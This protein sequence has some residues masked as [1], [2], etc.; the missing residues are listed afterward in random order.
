MECNCKLLLH[1]IYTVPRQSGQLCPKQ[2]FVLREPKLSGCLLTSLCPCLLPHPPPCAG[3]AG[4]FLRNESWGREDDLLTLQYSAAIFPQ[5]IRNP[6]V[7]CKF[8][9]IR[10]AALGLQRGDKELTLY[11]PSSSHWHTL[12]LFHISPSAPHPIQYLTAE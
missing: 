1:P 9:D 8:W 12:Q 5:S 3:R 4:V 11:L 10:V 6:A 7:N 2:G